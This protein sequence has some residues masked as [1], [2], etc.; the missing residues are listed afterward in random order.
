MTNE[1]GQ[2]TN[3][4]GGWVKIPLLPNNVGKKRVL[5][6]LRPSQW[7]RHLLFTQVPLWKNPSNLNIAYPTNTAS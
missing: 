2:N 5:A 3:S 7:S 4:K 1:R 6:N